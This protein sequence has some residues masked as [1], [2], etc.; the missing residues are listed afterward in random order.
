[1]YILC[2]HLAQAAAQAEQRK[3]AIFTELGEVSWL[4]I[5]T[6]I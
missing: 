6:S 5:A 3:K 4:N 1:M 2:W